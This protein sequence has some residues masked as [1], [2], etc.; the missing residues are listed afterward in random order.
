M[1]CSGNLARTSFTNST[2][3]S[4]YPLATSR[5]INLTCG[6]ASRMLLIFSRSFFPLPELTAICCTKQT[7]RRKTRTVT[8]P[9]STRLFWAQHRDPPRFTLIRQTHSGPA[10][11]TCSSRGKGDWLLQL[12]ELTLPSVPPLNSTYP[13]PWTSATQSRA[14][15][16]FHFLKLSTWNSE[17]WSCWCKFSSRRRGEVKRARVAGLFRFLVPKPWP[18]PWASRLGG[19][20]EGKMSKT[21]LIK[22]LPVFL[23]TSNATLSQ[24]ANRNLHGLPPVLASPS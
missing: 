10:Q 15:L 22:P 7:K 21:P 23:F 2:K 5:Q 18:S 6:T 13:E 20:K 4:E 11:E 17:P 16:L 3:C 9:P 8:L 12:P 19:R 24:H 1:V 14:W